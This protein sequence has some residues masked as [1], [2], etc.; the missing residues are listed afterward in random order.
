MSCTA[1]IMFADIAGSTALYE[2]IGDRAALDRIGTCLDRLAVATRAVGGRVVKT[3]G[4]EVMCSFNQVSD[5]IRAATEMQLVQEAAVAGLGLKIGF[6]FGEVILR[7]GDVFGDTV[8]VASRVAGLAKAG[9]ILATEPSLRQLPPYLRSAVR[10]MGPIAVRGKEQPL[11]VCEIVWSWTE[12]MTMMDDARQGEDAQGGGRL[13]VEYGAVTREFTVSD[14]AI[15][16][17]RAVGNNL[18]VDCPKASRMHA[19][20]EARQSGFVLVDL[21]SNGT[22]I[23]PQSGAEI[24]LRREEALLQ[25]E[26]TIGLGAPVP[27]SG[28]GGVRYRAA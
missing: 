22:Y 11:A 16:F 20:I 7:D 24:I 18:V 2:R 17:G 6:H 21:S 14:G 12:N 4:D 28:A 26:G 1:A 27:E 19:R 5:A 13:V 23:R 8:N 10:A 9:Q 15:S 3:I 25:G